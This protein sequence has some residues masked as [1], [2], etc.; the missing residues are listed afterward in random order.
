MISNDRRF[1]GTKERIGSFQRVLEHMRLHAK[2][3]EFDAIAS[4][5]R[6]DTEKMQREVLEYRTS[7]VNEMGN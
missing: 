2:P 6:A 4:G 3:E 7:H 1:L 5:Y